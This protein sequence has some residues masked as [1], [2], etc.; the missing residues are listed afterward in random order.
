VIRL[1]VSVRDASEALE[2]ALGGADVIDVKEPRLGSLGAASPETHKAVHD[3]VR[4]RYGTRAHREILLSSACGELLERNGN[5]NPGQLDGYAFAKIGLAGCSEA[6]NWQSLWC[7]WME[8]LPDHV[9]PVAVMYADYAAARAPNPAQILRVAESTAARTLLVDT[10]M[11]SNGDLFT[12]MPGAELTGI[13]HAARGLGFRIVLAGS[14]SFAQIT[15]ALQF[16]PDW[17][18][19]RGAV[20]RSGRESILD[21]DLVK[22]FVMRLSTPGCLN[23]SM[24]SAPMIDSVRTRP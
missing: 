22:Q 4:S 16:E 17:I 7:N 23:A 1:L 13:V 11:K 3:A 14:I 10:C 12:S 9:A 18:A 20:C 8:G 21:R 15:T 5:A 24:H 19:V 2:A 6:K